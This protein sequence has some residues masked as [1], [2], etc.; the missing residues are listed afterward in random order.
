M[1]SL[2]TIVENNGNWKVLH[3][4]WSL[5]QSFLLR[6]SVTVYLHTP[7]NYVHM[8]VKLLSS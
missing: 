1:F 4:I 2:R 3:C 8:H 6:Q 5:L 7:S